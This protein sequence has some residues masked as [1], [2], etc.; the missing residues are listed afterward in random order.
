KGG[1]AELAWLAGCW[2]NSVNGRELRE[3]WLP[4]RGGMLIGAAQ[5]TMQGVMQDYEFL[6]IDSRE[7]AVEFTQ[8]GTGGRQASF[9]LA[10]TTTDGNDTIYTFDHTTPSF[11]ARLVYRRGEQGWLYETVEGTL[12]GGAKRVIYPL[13]RVDCE[14][15]ELITK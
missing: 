14:T 7:G 1:V 13:R 4:L 15:G 12:A 8:F 11:P 3:E 10:G 2:Q 9:R 5:Q 6:R